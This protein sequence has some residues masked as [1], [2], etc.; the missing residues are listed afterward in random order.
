M[1]NISSGYTY[2]FKYVLCVIAD[3]LRYAMQIPR[4][5]TWTNGAIRYKGLC[6]IRVMGYEGFD[7]NLMSK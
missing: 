7:Y 3:L 1:P 4:P 6:V 5:P 2:V